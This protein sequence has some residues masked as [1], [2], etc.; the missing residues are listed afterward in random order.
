MTLAV[1]AT[2]PVLIATIA[3]AF[4][5]LAVVWWLTR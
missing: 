5:L 1:G 4:G 3:I 2:R